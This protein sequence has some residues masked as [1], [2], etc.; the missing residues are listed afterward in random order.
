MFV[1]IIWIILCCRRYNQNKRIRGKQLI[2]D[3]KE[4]ILKILYDHLT[5]NTDQKWIPI[6]EIQKQITDDSKEW[7]K[8]EREVDKDANTQKSLQMKD[9]VQKLC[10]KLSETAL[11]N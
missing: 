8:I 4:Q 9:G 5:H 11:I 10:W 1:I 6:M 2:K 7:K 3:K